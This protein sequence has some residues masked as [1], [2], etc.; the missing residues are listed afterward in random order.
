MR[1]TIEYWE[2]V[3]PPETLVHE[4][5]GWGAVKT[6]ERPSVLTHFEKRVGRFGYAWVSFS[7]SV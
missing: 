3:W 6:T 5:Y 7:P 1:K 4:G 2:D